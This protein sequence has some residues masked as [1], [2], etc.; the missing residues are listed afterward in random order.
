MI[1][2]S[3]QPCRHDH[4]HDSSYA[5][6]AKGVTNGNGHDHNGGDGAQIDHLNLANIGTNTHDQIDTFIASGG[7]SADAWNEQLIQDE[8]IGGLATTGNV[9]SLGWYIVTP[10]TI[11]GVALATAHPGIIDIKTGSTAGIGGLIVDPI[12]S[13]GTCYGSGFKYVGFIVKPVTNWSTA[14]TMHFGFQTSFNTGDTSTGYY[15]TK[16]DGDTHWWA[17]KAY[18]GSPSRTDTGVAWTAGNWYLLEIKHV[19]TNFLFYINTNLVSTIAQD[20]NINTSGGYLG[21]MFEITN[22]VQKELLLDWF[23]V[24]F[25][26]AMRWT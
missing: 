16:K 24:E 10:L 23:G 14:G 26:A 21:L 9:G 7:A 13:N 25:T 8:F 5:P 12:A 4:L 6:I 17:C 11:A 1:I 22:T 19:G 15:F 18:G 20:T 2:I 3:R